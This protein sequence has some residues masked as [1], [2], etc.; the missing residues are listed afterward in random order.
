MEDSK[1]ET[2]RE[3]EG[4]RERSG[5][6]LEGRKRLREFVSFVQFIQKIQWKMETYKGSYIGFLD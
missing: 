4:E 3:N 5:R 2:Q 6:K 1:R